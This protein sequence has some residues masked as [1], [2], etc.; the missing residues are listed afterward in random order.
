MAICIGDLNSN[1]CWDV[2]D[3]WWSHSDVVKEL[4]DLGLGSVYHV[5]RSEDQGK[6]LTPTFFMNR[7]LNK[8]YHIDYA[9]I[10]QLLLQGASV[11]VGHPE[12]WLEYSDHMPLIVQIQV[13]HS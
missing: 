2:W 7:K 10:S 12:K 9:F 13:G 3:R 8:P 1:T 4:K 6:E 11:D 5:T